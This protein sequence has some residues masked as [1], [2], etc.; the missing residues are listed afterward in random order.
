[1]K[2][3]EQE[4]T[5][6]APLRGPNSLRRQPHFINNRRLAE[7]KEGSP[8]TQID[9]RTVC[10]AAY[11]KNTRARRPRSETTHTRGL[12]VCLACI[13]AT[14]SWEIVT[15]FL[16]YRLFFEESLM[17]LMLSLEPRIK[18]P[19]SSQRMIAAGSLR[20]VS[21]RRCFPSLPGGSEGLPAS[22]WIR[23][24]SEVVGISG[25]SLKK[26]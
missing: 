10:A 12:P 14:P 22:R 23:N 6:N 26:R 19:S 3:R 17:L 25:D 11:S 8:Q 16:T 9:A 24:L 18:H 2:C 15:M 7:E 1:M 5:A 20:H 13:A 4:K 21:D